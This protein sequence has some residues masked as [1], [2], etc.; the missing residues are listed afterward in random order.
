MNLS[1]HNRNSIRIPRYDYSQAGYYYITI[2]TEK[3][4][5]L[6]GVIENSQIILSDLGIIVKECWED[7]PNHFPNISLDQWII[8]PNHLHGILVI[9]SKDALTPVGVQDLEPLQSGDC[10]YHRFQHISKQSIGAIV[11]SF[12]GTVTREWHKE[13]PDQNIWQRNY[14]ERV[15]RNEKELLAFREY[16]QNNVLSWELDSLNKSNN[17]NRWK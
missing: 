16:I 1:Y 15:V 2:C 8:M 13:N 3:H 14:W 11:Q 6:F 17:D 12:K 7:I 4:E 5:D 9:S 10:S